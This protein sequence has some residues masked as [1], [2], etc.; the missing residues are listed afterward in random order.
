MVGFNVLTIQK[1]SLL[2]VEFEWPAIR[3]IN[4]CMCDGALGELANCVD[5]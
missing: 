4:V 1:Y 5:V 3:V 2:G